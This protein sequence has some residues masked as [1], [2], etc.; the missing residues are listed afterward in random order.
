MPT[1]LSD[2]TGKLQTAAV[3]V[4]SG[5][6][7][8]CNGVSAMAVQIVGISVATISFE[9]NVDGANWVPVEALNIAT[10]T[11]APVATTDGIYLV[12]VLGFSQL[13]ARISAY[14]SGAI[15]VTFREIVG[16][17]VGTMAAPGAGA[18][19]AAN[20]SIADGVV[21]ANK[22]TVA[23]FHNTDHQSLPANSF[24]LNTGGVAQMLT[25][26]GA[27]DRQRE[28]SIDGI[29]AA[30]IATGSSQ[31]AQPFIVSHAA[32]V[33]TGL[34]KVLTPSAMS[35]YSS[36]APWSIQPGSTVL[37]EPTP[38]NGPVPAGYE[39][40]YVL[41]VTATT[42]TAA[43]VLKAHTGP[44]NIQGFV[45]NQS[46]DATVADGSP[47]IGFAA[48]GTYLFNQTLN[49]GVGGWERERSANGEL[50]GA[51]GAG[52]AT[53][54][55]QVYN[56]GGPGGGNYDRSRSLQGKLRNSGLLNGAVAA[57]VSS[58]LLSAV[59]GL[60]P[61]E[62]ITIGRGTAN[63]EAV[64][65]LATYVAGT[66]TVGFSSST[67]NAHANTEIAEWDDFAAGGPGLNGFT[68]TGITISEEALFNP[69]D[70]LYYG[71]RA[72]TQD[73]MPGANIVAESSVEWNGNTFDRARTPGV[74][75][76]VAAVAI[77]AG[78]PVAVWTPTGG[79]RF[80]VMGFAL[81]LSVAG[82]IILKDAA[83]EWI[84][85][86]L[87]IAATPFNSPPNMDNGYSS[88]LLNNILNLDATATG[89]VSGFIFGTEE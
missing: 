18:G 22:A 49:G 77:T 84:R 31:N 21:A 40:V 14:T 33:T 43:A 8:S 38:T 16:L 5:V 15:N 42:F 62:Q 68:P 83:A 12:S 36:G 58:I 47:G 29:A 2:Y 6:P 3:A 25:A 70:G 60:Q 10:N 32:S 65:V 4:G 35:G 19:V 82:S 30:G 44:F 50:D 71:E 23:A 75:K 55:E 56:G 52:A 73:G 46:R 64:Y 34:N 39:A 11:E 69:I 27:L 37:L 1:L 79:K 74:W 28:T 80:R 41:S 48:A 57:G 54:V 89:T 17:S 81:S 67:V 86:P 26:D 51:S 88:A 9:G 63:L 20:V 59:V 85:T 61:G 53:A 24:G 45:Y 78:T 13:R 66:L 72:A 76:T 87:L 7:A